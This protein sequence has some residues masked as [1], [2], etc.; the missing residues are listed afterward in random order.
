MS[1]KFRWSMTENEFKRM[2]RDSKGKGYLGH[3]T[4]GGVATGNFLVE[5]FIDELGD[6]ELPPRE[7]FIN[8]FVAGVDDDYGK[9]EDGTPYTYIDSEIYTEKMVFDKSFEDFKQSVE[10]QFENCINNCKWWQDIP[11]TNKE[12]RWYGFK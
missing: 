8:T 4:Y 1:R 10:T 7:I 5:F 9:L 12:I 3:N 2:V 11:D 6:E